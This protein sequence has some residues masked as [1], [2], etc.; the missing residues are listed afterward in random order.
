[1]AQQCDVLM[2]AKFRSIE[3]DTQ[4][5]QNQAQTIPKQQTKSETIQKPTETQTNRQ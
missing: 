5:K 3:K 1:M 2:A 4:T